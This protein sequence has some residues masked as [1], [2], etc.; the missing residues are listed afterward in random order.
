MNGVGW[1]VLVVL[2]FILI[3]GFFAAA[4]MALVSLRE[5]QLRALSKRGKRGQR[6]A[7]LAHDPNRFLSAVQ[8]GVTVA[9]LM[10]GAYG[11][12]TLAHALE[13]VLTPA[14]PPH[15]ASV[16]AFV[17]VTLVIA[18][19]SL[20]LGELAPKRIALQRSEQI[21]LVAAP[22]LDR[23]ATLARPVVWLISVCVNL[24]VRML[25]GDPKVGKG[26]IS[27]EELRDLVA[28]HQN[29]SVDER[30]IVSEVFDAGKRQIREV[31]V[32]R[33]EVDFLPAS[34]PLAQ[35]V[36]VAAR[37]THSRFPVFEDS[38]DDVVG[39]VHARDLLNPGSN[40]SVRVGD[41]SRPV[42]MLPTSKTVMSALSEMRKDRAHLAIVID[43]YGGTAGIVTLEDLVEELIGDIQDEYDAEGHPSRRLR[44]GEIEV[45]GL[46]NLDDFAD[47]SG[48]ELPDGPY[49][50]VAG[51]LLSALGHLP[52]TG[53][54]VEFDGSRLTVTE[55]DG[56]RIARVKVSE[57]TGGPGGPAVPGGPGGP[58]VPGGPGEP[59]VPG[60][61]G[62]PAVPSGPGEPAVPGGPGEPAVPGG[63][64]EPTV[65]GGPAESAVAGGPAEPTTPG[66]PTG[67]DD[68]PGA[69]GLA[70][71]NGDGGGDQ[72][73]ADGDRSARNGQPTVP[74]VPTG[75]VG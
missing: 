45:D 31:L 59:A 73:P 39:F 43:E 5:G 68:A 16:V 35:A 38:Y 2:A 37:A 46:M 20:V 13:H 18:F 9:T 54:L 71:A 56:R 29:L 55:L 50:T 61:P 75:Q 7:R 53:E 32:P 8:I 57:L 58:A 30:H 44:T 12:A 24:V 60:G 63:R 10:S 47:L 40:G 3:G 65:P 19:F 48:I 15:V 6:A 72:R 62:E 21:S 28:G 1:D 66:G 49:E 69:A 64:G 70:L 25:G 11:A 51:F 33:T 34:M 4:E 74:T 27:S 36:V 41:I 14:L 22:V 52:Q 67:A 23:I 17:C 26:A 42:K